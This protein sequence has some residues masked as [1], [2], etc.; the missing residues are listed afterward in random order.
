PYWLAMDV[1]NLGSTAWPVTV[2]TFA[3][4]PDPPYD[5]EVFLQVTWRSLDDPSRPRMVVPV[6]LTRDV[7]A[8]E[9]ITQ[10]TLLAR[11][12][13]PGRYAIEIAVRQRNGEGFEK[14]PSRA[15]RGEIEVR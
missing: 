3:P 9:S 2:P 5:G 11:P 12:A 14:P 1:T 4:P 15:L 10:H 8:Q 6:Q 7:A 13:A